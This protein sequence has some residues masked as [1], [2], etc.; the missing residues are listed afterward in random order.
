MDIEGVDVNMVLPRVAWRRSPADDVAVEMS[1]YQAYHRFP[2]GLLR[3]VPGS[4]H[5]A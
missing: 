5:E 1:M 3:A 2:Q 4:P